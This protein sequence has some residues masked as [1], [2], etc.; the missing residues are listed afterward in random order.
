[1][2]D[3]W[4]QAR[5]AHAG[6]GL[7]ALHLCRSGAVDPAGLAAFAA[8]MAAKPDADAIDIRAAEYLGVV[9]RMVTPAP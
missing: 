2:D 8:D 3:T 7:L 9:A 5:V 6:L 1:M 4:L